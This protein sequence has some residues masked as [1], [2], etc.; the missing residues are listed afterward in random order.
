MVLSLLTGPTGDPVGLDH[1]KKQINRGSVTDDDEFIANVLIPAA[2]E[3]GEG[4]TNRAFLTQT[5][6]A[7]LDA[8]P[9]CDW[10]EVPK[11]PLQGTVVDWGSGVNSIV[12]ITYV[13]GD[14]VTQRLIEGTDYVVD[15]PVGPRCA[16]GRIALV[17]GRS[18]PSTRQQINAVSIKFKA[19]YGTSAEAIPAYLRMGML[20][21]VGALFDNR[22]SV[23]A[24]QAS[25]VALPEFAQWVYRSFRSYATQ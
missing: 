6:E 18:W 12:L 13:D 1:A 14:G 23:L 20:M 11:P 19:G 24:G 9:D 7:R 5:W 22:E 21:D 10:L 16:R 3:R 4:L 17:Y 2:A 15:A 25:G 8:F